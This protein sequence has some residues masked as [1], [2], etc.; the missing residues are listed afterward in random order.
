MAIEVFRGEH[1]FLSNMYPFKNGITTPDGVIVHTS[2][3]LYLPARLVHKEDR[4]AVEEAPSG[5]R[6]KRISRQL[7]NAGHPIRP[8]WDMVRVPIMRDCILVKFAANIALRD[9]LLATANEEL[10]EGNRWGDI[11]WGVSPPPPDGTGENM[12]GRLLM[13]ARE[14]FRSPDFS[15]DIDELVQRIFDPNGYSEVLSPAENA[16]G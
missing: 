6:A 12:L 7:Q 1:F 5:F 8:G 13:D 14:G 15:I 11:F 3:Q 2:E 10:I 9:Q 4:L 16:G